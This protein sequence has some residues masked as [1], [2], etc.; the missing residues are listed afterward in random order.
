[1]QTSSP[2][3]GILGSL[4]LIDLTAIAILV[5]FFVLGLFRG[6]VWQMSRIL[7]LVMAYVAAG[8]YGHEVAAKIGEWFPSNTSNELPLY[9]A[10]FTVFLIV[11]V[12]IS[13]LASFLERLLEE[14]GLSMLNRVGGGVLGLGT[15][16][17][18]VV[19]LLAGLLMFTAEDSTAVAAAQRS[20]SMDVSRRTIEVLGDVVPPPVREV[21]GLNDQGQISGEEPLRADPAT[22]RSVTEPGK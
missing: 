19:G 20:R 6:F 13:L 12:L 17:F 9:V 16:A 21:F 7:T 22:G 2:D 4:G 11:L 15:G 3:P 1:M 18:V 5:V 8:V 14:S 10:Y